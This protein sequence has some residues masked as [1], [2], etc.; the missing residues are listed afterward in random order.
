M[1]NI[2]AAFMALGIQQDH[3]KFDK[4]LAHWGAGCLE[5]IEQL[6]AYAPYADALITA[7]Y[8]QAGGDPGVAM[9]EVAEE[10]GVWFG[11]EVLQLASGGYSPLQSDC[12]FELKCLVVNFFREGRVPPLRLALDKVSEGWI[13]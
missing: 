1:S 7:G 9:Y 11:D 5:L 13:K 6:V 4:V 3:A 10:F 8:A 12:V 2:A